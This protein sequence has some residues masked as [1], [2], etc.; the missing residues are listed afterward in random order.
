MTLRGRALLGTMLL[1]A[2]GK[3]LVSQ[4]AASQ[5]ASSGA[6]TAE[7]TFQFERMG[8]PVPQL[9]VRVHEDGTGSYQAEQAAK[10]SND[11]PGRGEDAQHIDRPITLSSSTI[12]KIFKAS[13]ELKYF[14]FP[15]ASKAKNVADTGKKTLSYAG[16]DGQGACIYNYS[17]DKNVT[18]LTNIFQGIAFTLDEGRSLEHLHRYDRL[19][20]DAE[21]EMLAREVDQGRA[22]ELGTIA[23]TLSS[24]A[25]DGAVIQRVRLRAMKML[26]QSK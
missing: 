10:T 23:P 20:L 7:V 4:I 3:P 11:W 21:M 22:L 17:D 5:P 12:A 24:I 25:D 13:R 1:L 16:P 18:L 6:S 9:T 14:D 26:E 15:C 19:G 8:V 2:S